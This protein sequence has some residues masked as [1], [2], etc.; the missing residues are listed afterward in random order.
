[1]PT[2]NGLQDRRYGP[3]LDNRVRRLPRQLNRTPVLPGFGDCVFMPAQP[4]ANPS[5]AAHNDR[6]GQAWPEQ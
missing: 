2:H 1:M 5:Q 6:L 4:I 3:L